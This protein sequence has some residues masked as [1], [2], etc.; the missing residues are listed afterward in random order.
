MKTIKSHQ[1]SGFILIEVMIALVLFGIMAYGGLGLYLEVQRHKKQL[2][3][4]ERQEKILRSL[5]SYALIYGRLPWAAEREGALESPGQEHRGCTQGTVPFKTLGLPF[6]ESQD[7]F[8]R[9][10]MYIIATT[11]SAS[12]SV[13]P[14]EEYC[15]AYPA[16]SLHYAGYRFE[17]DKDF[18][19]VALLSGGE[20]GNLPD[21]QRSAEGQIVLAASLPQGASQVWATRNMLIALYGGLSCGPFHQPLPDTKTV[22]SSIPR[23]FG[24]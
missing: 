22:G 3:T 15:R 17:G 11:R 8:G 20:L 12:V 21:L 1:Q 2:E 4:R 7:G 9:P 24:R 6:V 19:I 10:F 18:I 23:G 16:Y 5:A 14:W 13:S